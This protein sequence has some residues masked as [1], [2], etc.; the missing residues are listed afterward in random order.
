MSGDASRARRLGDLGPN[1]PAGWQWGGA[2]EQLPHLLLM[3]YAFA[4]SA[5]P[6]G[7]ARCCRSATRASSSSATSD[8]CDMHGVEPFGFAD[9]ISEP[10]IDWLRE[11]PRRDEEVGRYYATCRCLGEY[12]LG[13]PNEYGGYTD[14]PLLDPAA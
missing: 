9:G 13:Y 7:G 2:P 5:S 3:L 11:R 1:D 14:R 4:R 6:P 12:L 10:S 8:T